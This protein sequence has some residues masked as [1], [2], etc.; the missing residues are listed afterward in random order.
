[1]CVCV[2]GFAPLC[3]HERLKACDD[4]IKRKTEELDATIHGHAASTELDKVTSLL[5]R[6]F[7]C[8]C[9]LQAW[10]LSAECVPDTEV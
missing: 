8:R 7:V 9:C 3:S 6:P 10:Q 4:R 2:C 5:A 1:M